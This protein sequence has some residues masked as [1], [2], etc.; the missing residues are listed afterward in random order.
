MYVLNDTGNFN[1]LMVKTLNQGQIFYH[2]YY[3]DNTL[4]QFFIDFSDFI[5]H[6]NLVEACEK[7]FK[8][9]SS[10]FR[11]LRHKHNQFLQAV[12]VKKILNKNWF[13]NICTTHVFPDFNHLTLN[14]YELVFL[15]TVVKEDLVSLTIAFGFL[16]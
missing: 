2:F 13:I 8:G 16:N 7:I 4:Q 5:F 9:A 14:P 12:N 10:S 15:D 11:L 1:T 6:V 3:F